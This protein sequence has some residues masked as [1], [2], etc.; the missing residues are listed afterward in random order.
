M[1]WMMQS[2]TSPHLEPML[3]GCPTSVSGTVQ[4]KLRALPTGMSQ[5]ELMVVLSGVAWQAPCYSQKMLTHEHELLGLTLHSALLKLRACVRIVFHCMAN[6][7]VFR[8]VELVLKY[9]AH[10]H[11]RVVSAFLPLLFPRS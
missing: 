11:G 3:C 6:I 9:T 8:A 10:A 4:G 2:P 1:P 5:R 7:L